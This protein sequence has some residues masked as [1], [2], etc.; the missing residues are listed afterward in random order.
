M[1][2]PRIAP[3][4][5]QGIGRENFLVKND[6]VAKFQDGHAEKQPER[7]RIKLIRGEFFPGLH[8][9]QFGGMR[10][11]MQFQQTDFERERF[12]HIRMQHPLGFVHDL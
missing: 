3:V 4:L 12:L 9:P 2:R 1:R 11:K 7:E 5:R 8:W 6:R 10:S